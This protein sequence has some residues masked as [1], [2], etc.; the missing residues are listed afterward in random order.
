MTEIP[1]LDMETALWS[2]GIS[3]I[4]GVDESGRGPLAGPVVAAAVVFP[5]FCWFEGVRDSKKMTRRQRDIVYQVIGSKSIAWGI[6]VVSH[7]EIDRINIY[8]A[9]L[10]A[11]KIAVRNLGIVPGHLLV[12]GRAAPDIP[13]SSTTVIRGDN[14][15]FTIAAASILAKVTRDRIM[16]ELDNEFPQYGFARHK[17]YGTRDHVEAIRTHGPSRIHRKSFKVRG[18]DK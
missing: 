7:D 11:M 2:Q 17:G 13:V 14:R 5:D 8:Q 15:C 10:K 18:W 6:G 12:D 1:S 4:A 9:S 3:R 16:M